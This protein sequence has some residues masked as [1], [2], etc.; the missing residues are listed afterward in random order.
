GAV[1]QYEG[2]RVLELWGTREEMAHAQGYLLAE[3]ILLLVDDFAHSERNLPDLSI[4]TNLILPSQRVRFTRGP[5]EDELK[6]MLRGMQERLGAANVRSKRLERAL[7]VDDLMAVNSIPDWNGLMCSTFT[8]WGDMTSDQNTLTVRNLDYNFTPT[9]VKQQLIAVV[10]GDEQRHGFVAVTWPGL[11]GVFTAVNDQ[12][13]TMLS[14]DSNGLPKS[15]NEGYTARG[16]IFR[17]AMENA[18]ARTA[19]ADVAETF[20]KH[21]VIVGNNMHV[22]TAY[23]GLDNP[24][25]IFEYDGNGRDGGLTIRTADDDDNDQLTSAICCT[26]HVRKR[27]EIRECNRYGI[28]TTALRET[29]KLNEKLKWQE[30]L[31]L[32]RKAAVEETLHTVVFEN[33][34]G[35]MHVLIPA[36]K[37]SPVTVPYEEWLKKSPTK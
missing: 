21:R 29:V 6:A 35:I 18:N 7:S 25:Q 36:V 22:S 4:Y 3:D 13:V 8:A 19:F 17:A 10:H 27:G 14:H 28:L 23:N 5:A 11:L 24:A 16:L 9:M 2:L 34:K 31:E 15:Y 20:K 1:R 37:N 30:A 12:N 33:N 32:G 26:N